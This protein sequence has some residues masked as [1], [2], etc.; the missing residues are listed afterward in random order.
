MQTTQKKILDS[1]ELQREQ[2][3][4]LKEKFHDKQINSITEKYSQEN[5]PLFS[6]I[7][8]LI[9]SCFEPDYSY[10]VTPQ[11]MLGF[12]KKISSG[13]EFSEDEFETGGDHIIKLN[14]LY[15]IEKFPNFAKRNQIDISLCDEIKLFYEKRLGSITKLLNTPTKEIKSPNALQMKITTNPIQLEG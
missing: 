9:I 12:L 5:K 15:N 13:E 4:L 14:K 10:E 6:T 3:Y 1:E 11:E 7:N 2:F 8:K